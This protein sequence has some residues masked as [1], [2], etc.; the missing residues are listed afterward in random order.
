MWSQQVSTFVNTKEGKYNYCHS[1]GFLR[2]TKYFVFSLYLSKWYVSIV[3]FE[4]FLQGKT[5]DERVIIRDGDLPVKEEHLTTAKQKYL[6]KNTKISIEFLNDEDEP[7]HDRN[8]EFTSDRRHV[9]STDDK[10]IRENCGECKS[11]R[12]LKDE[13]Q[14][15]LLRLPKRDWCT[16]GSDC[17]KCE[18]MKDGNFCWKAIYD[19]EFIGK[20]KLYQIPISLNKL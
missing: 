1:F 12:S 15:L 7:D 11:S 13:L 10:I 4:F 20:Y 9:I 6:A 16:A 19:I 3:G 18:M 8:V 2:Y 14:K 17:Q 5:G